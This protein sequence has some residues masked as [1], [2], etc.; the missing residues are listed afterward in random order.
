MYVFKAILS[1]QR[2]FSLTKL[3]QSLNWAIPEQ[4][5]SP[6][7]GHLPY[8]NPPCLRNFQKL[9]SPLPPNHALGIFHFFLH[10]LWKYRQIWL[11]LLYFSTAGYRYSLQNSLLLCNAEMICFS[12]KIHAKMPQKLFN[13]SHR[14][15]ESWHICCSLHMRK[16]RFKSDAGCGN[17]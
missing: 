12:D 16:C 3:A 17:D 2:F 9:L 4:I 14:I 7:C 15:W 5:P 8:L 10:T 13:Q 1:I 11:L 6:Y